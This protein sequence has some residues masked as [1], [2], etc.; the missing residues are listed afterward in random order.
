MACAAFRTLDASADEW[1]EG[2]DRRDGLDETPDRV[3][4]RIVHLPE[5][6]KHVGIR[7][8]PSV[9]VLF[10]RIPRRARA[11]KTTLEGYVLHGKPAPVA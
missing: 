9:V 1:N 7:R 2:D 4:K 10:V 6:R 8:P 3:S 11:R 5:L